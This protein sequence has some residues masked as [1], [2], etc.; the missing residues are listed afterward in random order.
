M[1]KTAPDSAALLELDGHE[2]RREDRLRADGSICLILDRDGAEA[3]TGRLIDVSQSGFRASHSSQALTPGRV[4]RFHYA[5]RE[6]G[7]QKSGWAR[8]IWSR[9]QELLIET[10]CYIV[11]AD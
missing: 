6:S 1:K 3:V 2:K 9:V 7:R 8:V 11:I 4:I 5:D 10:G